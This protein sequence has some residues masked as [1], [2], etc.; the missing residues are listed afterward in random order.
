MVWRGIMKIVEA[1]IAIPKPAKDQKIWNSL[2]PHAKPNMVKTRRQPYISKLDPALSS[3][4]RV[5]CSTTVAADAR[6]RPTATPKTAIVFG[7]IVRAASRACQQR[8][9]AV[10]IIREKMEELWAAVGRASGDGDETIK[11][12][13]RSTAS[14]PQ[15]TCATS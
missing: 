11:G 14:T 8:K 6:E 13:R 10:R 3:H 7:C 1:A 15:T 5:A 2:S 12:T 4:M 9:P